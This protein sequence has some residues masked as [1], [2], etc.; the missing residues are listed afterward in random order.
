M[1]EEGASGPATC[2]LTSDSSRTKCKCGSFPSYVVD[3]YDSQN[4]LL[5]F[6]STLQ[7]PLSCPSGEEFDTATNPCKAVPTTSTVTT[8]E[9]T[10]T[11]QPTVTCTEDG[12]FPLLPSCSGY[13][14]CYTVGGS[15]ISTGVVSCSDPTP[16]FN[17]DTSS[18]VASITGPATPTCGATDIVTADTVECNAFYVCSNSATVGEK[19]CCGEGQ[20]FNPVTIS[21]ETDTGS[22][23][24]PTVNPCYDGEVVK[25]CETSTSTSASPTSSSISS[26]SSS[27]SSA[28]S[29]STT[30]N[31]SETDS[32][33]RTISTSETESSTSTVSTSETD[34]S[35]STVSTSETDS[36][37]STVSTSETDS[38]T[39]TVSTSETDSSTSTVS[40]SETDSSTSTVSTSET[41]SSTS[42]VS[43]S[44]T[45]SS[46]S[47]VSTSE[48]DSSTSTVS[49]SETDS[50]TS[51][52]STS[53]TD[54]TSS[55][56]TSTTSSTPT[57]GAPDCTV[58]SGTF[59][60]PGDCTKAVVQE[61]DHISTRTQALRLKSLLQN[62]ATE[63]QEKETH[64]WSVSVL[65]LL[66]GPAGGTN[67]RRESHLQSGGWL[68]HHF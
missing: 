22:V 11:T 47:T 62:L 60:Y 30:I 18:C 15:V 58:N 3:S 1:C 57:A 68:Y 20:V 9:V 42:T 19:I 21:C 59:P 39:S 10:T 34:S 48:T 54:D 36:S 31:T 50:S 45:D 56:S 12:L 53:E 26:S 24:C 40:T 16:V 63:C 8:T 46:T 28:S 35:T 23:T 55:T 49:T 37:T 65:L 13:Y 4:Y 25:A 64:E 61:R 2:A 38:S 29:T 41:D 7:I 44:E 27:T 67:L 52:V 51:T 14:A 43:T 66:R 32:S 17:P 33:T 6:S 5:C